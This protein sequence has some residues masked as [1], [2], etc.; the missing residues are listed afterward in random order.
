MVYHS[1]Q[2]LPEAALP[3]AWWELPELQAGPGSQAPCRQQREWVGRRF[4]DP[5][6]LACIAPNSD[7][8]G[9]LNPCYQVLRE[10]P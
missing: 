5:I 7:T 9:I 4:L 8:V 3:P 6:D 10:K 1:A 2:D